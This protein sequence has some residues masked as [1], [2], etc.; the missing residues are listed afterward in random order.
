MAIANAELREIKQQTREDGEAARS[1]E[2]E[3]QP[4]DDLSSLQRAAAEKADQVEDGDADDLIASERGSL[5]AGPDI[6][7]LEGEESRSVADD[8]GTK[9]RDENLN[10]DEA[11]KVGV[12]YGD[13]NVR[14]EQ[15]NIDGI[16][17]EALQVGKHGVAVDGVEL[18]PGLKGGFQMGPGQQAANLAIGTELHVPPPNGWSQDLFD[19]DVPLLFGVVGLNFKSTFDNDLTLGDVELQVQRQSTDGTWTGDDAAETT[20]KYSILGS[21]ESS[22]NLGVSIQAAMYGGI[23]VAK[24]LAGIRAAAGVELGAQ[25]SVSGEY[26]ATYGRVKKGDSAL[27]KPKTST[28]AV[29]WSL[30]AEGAAKAA[31][32]LFAGFKV[33][34]F[35]GDLWTLELV[36][37]PLAN[38]EAGGAFGVRDG[39]GFA[40]QVLTDPKG[41]GSWFNLDFGLLQKKW[42][43]RKLDAAKDSST[44]TRADTNSLADLQSM[45][46]APPAEAESGGEGSQSEP[47]PLIDQTKLRGVIDNL[48]GSEKMMIAPNGE[49]QDLM[50]RDAIAE[51]LLEANRE[52]RAKLDNEHEEV[53][54][55]DKKEKDARGWLKR[56]VAGDTDKLKKWKADRKTVDDAI[57]KYLLERD[58]Y[59][60]KITAARQRIADELERLDGQQLTDKLRAA[61]NLKDKTYKENWKTFESE[62]AAS[63]KG[64]AAKRAA[65][66]KEVSDQ[67]EKVD[68]LA[69]E[70]TAARADTA[71]Q[72]ERAGKLAEAQ[73]RLD[74]ALEE[75]ARTEAR[76]NE[77]RKSEERTATEA[78][79]AKK[80]RSWYDMSSSDAERNHEAQKQERKRSEKAHA[81][82]K[83][84]VPSIRSEVNKL[85]K[86][87][88]V[89]IAENDYTKAFTTLK[90]LEKRLAAVTRTA[91]ADAQDDLELIA[92]TGVTSTAK[93]REAE[94]KLEKKAALAA[95]LTKAAGT[96]DA[97]R[98]KQAD[99]ANEQER[100]A[101]D[102]SYLSVKDSASYV[103]GNDASGRPDVMAFMEK[104]SGLKQYMAGKNK[105]RYHKDD[106]DTLKQSIKQQGVAL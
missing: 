5:T 61:A 3:T 39:Q 30:V 32:S 26:E 92:G 59:T 75:E 85:R 21:V 8:K 102:P 84:Q 98:K 60:T 65:V 72:E 93:G 55:A 68:R 27:Q 24:V 101:K 4:V 70:V 52:Q 66:E 29:T 87:N 15:E 106:L 12:G 20:V 100:I 46:L 69:A 1:V 103:L 9:G 31:L 45:V 40:D 53:V 71:S 99:R 7:M 97:L 91:N 89:A 28:S 19:V 35:E 34:I 62:F 23:P 44:K 104:S 17:F 22:Y 41:A 94:E 80:Q 16:P 79:A 77:A 25:M 56:K 73:R 50:N 58:Q 54:L 82:A 74:A 64:S 11:K 57:A 76:L 105:V 90:L 43:A 96:E 37:V 10:S 95:K 63:R 51:A 6:A 67:Q 49:I 33:F 48:R 88:P 36:N 78:A 83:A 42:K 38:V 47:K 86:N 14:L 81:T 18:A 13:G 2:A